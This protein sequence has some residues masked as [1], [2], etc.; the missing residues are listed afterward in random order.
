MTDEYF[1]VDPL[2][3]RPRMAG[4]MGWS[5]KTVERREKSDPTFPERVVVGR[6]RYAYR[7]SDVQRYI[8]SLPV[9]PRLIA[10]AA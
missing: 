5:I 7:A 6:G 9:A 3:P 2:I 10:A 4:I 8:D 1:G